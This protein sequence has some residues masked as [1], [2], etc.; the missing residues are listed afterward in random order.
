[1]DVLGADLPGLGQRGGRQRVVGH[2]V[3]LARQA[4]GGL[5]QRQHGTGLEQRQAG[6]GQAQAVIEV[7][8]QF[9]ACESAEVVSHDDALG[10]GF[11]HGQRHAKPV[12]EALHAWLSEQRQKLAKAD[13]TAKAIDYSL[14]NWRGLTHYLD[15]GHVP[16]DNNAAE[17]AVRP[18]AMARS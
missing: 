17:N 7:L 15:D 6:A 1:M 5:V 9:V 8:G 16:I 4:V 12:A 18:L 11:V 13:V 3:D 2:E 10:Q 14:S